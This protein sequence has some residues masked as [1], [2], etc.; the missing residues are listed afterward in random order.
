MRTIGIAPRMLAVFGV[1]AAAGVAGC[2]AG[3]VPH[4]VASVLNQPVTRS[5]TGS[6]GTAAASPSASASG[7]AVRNLVISTAVRSELTEAFAAVRNIP[8]SYVTGT[9]PG[10]VYYAYVPATDTYWALA[11]FELSATSIRNIPAGCEDGGCIG[12]FKQVATGAWQG[13]LGGIPAVCQ[14]VRFFPKAVL[15]AWS[16]PAS[17]PAPLN[18]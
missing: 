15:E 16:L 4:P 17:V 11:S 18:C 3:S 8:Q 1:L 12:M 2:S 9:Q 14:E 10:S 7:D 6:A 5:T 13:G